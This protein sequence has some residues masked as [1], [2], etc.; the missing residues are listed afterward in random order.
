MFSPPPVNVTMKTIVNAFLCD[1]FIL[2]AHWCY[3]T[4]DIEGKVVSAGYFGDRLL[5]PGLV[6]DY[7]KPKEAGD[8]THYGD[9]MFW[10]LEH[11][12][13]GNSLAGW[14]QKWLSKITDKAY[15]G[16]KDHAS[17]LVL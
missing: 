12:A 15:L 14:R 13:E 8:Q 10:L 4:A 2:P 17:L 16:Y 6:N 11:L 3:V 1:S 7:H 9:Q 5:A